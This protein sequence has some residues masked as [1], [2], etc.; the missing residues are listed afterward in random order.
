MA[1]TILLVAAC[2]L[3]AGQFHHLFGV[4]PILG[5]ILCAACFLR[6]RDLFLIGWG[7]ILIRDLLVAVDIFTGVRL[8]AITLVVLTVVAVKVRPTF[9]SLA[10]GLLISSPIFHLVLATGDWLT[11]YCSVFPKT[12]H[13]FAATVVTAMPYFQRSFVGDMAFTSLFL[14]L[15]ALAAYGLLGLRPQPA[16]T[17]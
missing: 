16:S 17:S 4:A 12:P 11:G 1:A 10:T 5:A 6:P 3:L 15:Y 7:G 9:R 2:G 14:S 8:V 13:G